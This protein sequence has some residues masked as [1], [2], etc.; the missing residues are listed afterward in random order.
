M[1]S[2]EIVSQLDLFAADAVCSDK[3]DEITEL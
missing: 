2:D 3:D 1:R